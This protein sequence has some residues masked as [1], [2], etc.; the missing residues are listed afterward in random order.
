MSKLTQQELVPAH[1]PIG[2]V[3]L[4]DKTLY[5]RLIKH[6]KPSVAGK[7]KYERVVIQQIRIV[8]L[9]GNDIDFEEKTE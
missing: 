6:I 7:D 2:T 9:L 3:N 8:D 4:G 1:L 5:F